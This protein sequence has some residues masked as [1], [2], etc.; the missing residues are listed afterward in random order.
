[1]VTHPAGYRLELGE[2][3]LDLL[4]FFASATDGRRFLEQHRYAE[5]ADR[6]REALAYRRGPALGDLR[7]EPFAAAETAALDEAFLAAVEAR[8]DADLALG[9][10]AE[11]VPEL[12]TLVEAQPLREQL[13]AQLMEALYRAGRGAD[14]LAAY[15]AAR[16]VL[17]DE[18]GV[19]P[20]TELQR[21]QQAILADAE[22]SRAQRSARPV[23]LLQDGGGHHRVVP[24]DASRS[25]LTIGRRSSNDLSLGW[26]LQVSRVHARLEWTASG[27]TL[28]DEGTS[29]NGSF[30][31]GEQVV[32]QR[33]LRDG[34]V[35]RLGRTV[36]LYRGTH[37]GRA[38]RPGMVQRLFALADL[39]VP[40]GVP[41]TARAVTEHDVGLL[42]R[43]LVAFSDDVFGGWRGPG[44]PGDGV[45]RTVA[46]GN[47]SLLWCVDGEPVAWARRALR[48]RA[49]PGSARCTRHRRG[50]D[51]AT[52]RR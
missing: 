51:A 23:L 17:L 48:W 32:G 40:T 49:C 16:A 43:W 30:V 1:M 29:R 5:A 15:R 12:T 33:Q 14:A 27:W 36:L 10:A 24:L 35:I 25:P 22:L 7:D 26:D 8:I 52:R 45:Q 9:R 2:H 13:H 31:D 39:V 42:T 19:N 3:Q 50:G 34:A 18:L 38:V 44:T 46:R 11:T 21:L 20:G 41:G 6:L 47:A 37:T 28:I 4:K